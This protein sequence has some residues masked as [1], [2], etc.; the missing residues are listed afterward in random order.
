MLEPCCITMQ[1]RNIPAAMR[2]C[3]QFP[4]VRENCGMARCWNVHICPVSSAAKPTVQSASTLFQYC[5]FMHLRQ[6]LT[7]SGAKKQ[8]NL[9]LAF[10]GEVGKL[11][12]TFYVLIIYF[13]G[14]WNFHRPLE[15]KCQV[16][17]LQKFTRISV[18]INVP[19]LLYLCHIVQ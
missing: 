3:S 8:G 12:F 19:K 6:A 11:H 16:E 10:E 9:N 18:G 14:F 15:G 2:W 4:G 17:H 7:L 13:Y 5:Y 1:W